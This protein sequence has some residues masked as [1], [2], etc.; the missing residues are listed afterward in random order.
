M[1][2]WGPKN[3]DFVALSDR[4]I[5]REWWTNYFFGLHNSGRGE[6]ADESIRV[7]E[8]HGDE[9]FQAWVEESERLAKEQDAR[10]SIGGTVPLEE[11]KKNAD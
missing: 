7:L 10:D 8:A 4:D 1:F 5:E 3:S 9:A 11:E 6:E 2:N